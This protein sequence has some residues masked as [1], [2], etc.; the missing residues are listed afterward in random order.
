MDLIN[1]ALDE[2]ALEGLEGTTIDGLWKLL[3]E[4]ENS[5]ISSETEIDENF[6]SFI[7]SGILQCPELEFFLLEESEVLA[8]QP[9]KIPKRKRPESLSNRPKTKGD[10]NDQN[11]GA[12]LPKNWVSDTEN[13]VCGYCPSYYRRRNITNVVSKPQ[14]VSYPEAV[15]KWGDNL[16]L[17]ASQDYRRATLFGPEQP[18]DLVV[19]DIRYTLLEIIGKSRHKGFF[20]KDFT[21]FS[22]DARSAFHHVKL[23][24][25]QGLITRQTVPMLGEKMNNTHSKLLFLKRFH[26]KIVK[27][28]HSLA[29]MMS[30]IISQQPGNVIELKDLRD[31]WEN[32]ND[33]TKMS[34]AK[35]K[36]VRQ[37]LHRHG[38]I[39]Y[40]QTGEVVKCEEGT[41]HGRLIASNP[42]Y[43]HLIKPY[44]VDEDDEDFD[45]VQ[46][47]EE[48]NLEGLSFSKELFVLRNFLHT[49]IHL[50]THTY[51]HV[52]TYIE[53]TY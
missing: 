32:I 23:L 31:K 33:K 3:K 15:M 22:L 17:V 47:E 5:L 29:A 50:S 4:S 10:P 18:P 37:F 7:W 19:T 39:Q 16:F 43:I 38:Y 45:K 2:I 8:R 42:I 12:K 53:N 27:H 49:C 25:K 36:K 13:H 20:Q 1:Q 40:I 51:I 6:K 52:H 9:P 48:G 34:K 44:R 30:D 35:L 46:E 28:S 21:S 41:L 26:K 14:Q 24:A 11:G